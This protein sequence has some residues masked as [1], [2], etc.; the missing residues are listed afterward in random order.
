ME[1]DI[2]DFLCDGTIPAILPTRQVPEM[3]CDGWVLPPRIRLVAVIIHDRLAWE[4]P[5]YHVMEDT[6]T[7][8]TARVRMVVHELTYSLILW[9]HISACVRT[10]SMSLQIIPIAIPIR[11]SRMVSNEVVVWVSDPEAT[12]CLI[13]IEQ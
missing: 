5:W 4:L 7:V 12:R 13:G 6:Q 2:T 9:A 10:D 11:A 3:G 1:S 8:S